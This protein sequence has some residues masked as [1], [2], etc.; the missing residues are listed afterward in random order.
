MT[1]AILEVRI[2]VKIKKTI[3]R[4]LNQLFKALIYL[5]TRL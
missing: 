1:H 5:I 2:L 4:F 3:C